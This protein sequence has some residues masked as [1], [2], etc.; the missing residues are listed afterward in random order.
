[1]LLNNPSRHSNPKASVILKETTNQNNVW[2]GALKNTNQNSPLLSSQRTHPHHHQQPFQDHQAP[3]SISSV[4]FLVSVT[5]AGRFSGVSG[6]CP[7]LISPEIEP[8]F[9]LSTARLPHRLPGDR[10]TLPGALRGVKPAR[11]GR[12]ALRGVR[13]RPPGRSRHRPRQAHASWSVRL[14]VRQRESYAHSASKSNRLVRVLTPH[15]QP[16][17]AT[18]ASVAA[19]ASRCSPNRPR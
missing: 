6:G 15:G 12:C 14:S 1:M 10:F 9:E 7:S 17:V 4:R 13:L 8:C 3:G 16:I 2:S 5:L 11:P 18:S 19:R